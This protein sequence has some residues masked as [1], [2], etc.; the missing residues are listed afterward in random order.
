MA[1]ETALTFPCRDQQLVGIIHHPE[2]EGKTGVLIIVGGPQYRVGSHRQFVLLA[3]HLANAGIT[4]MRFD[5]GGMGDSQGQPRDFLQIDADIRAAIDA[6]MANCPA[7]QQVVLW[8]LCDAA[9]ATLFYGYQDSRV[10]GLVLLNPWVFTQQGAAKTYLK[11]YYLQRLVSKDF[12]R[13]VL[14]LKLDYR[15]SLLSLMG[16]LQQAAGGAA[17]KSTAVAKV[18]ANLPLPARMRQCLSQFNQPVLLILSGRDLTADEFKEVVKADLE[19]QTLL[20]KP[21]L[22]RQD[23]PE[24]DHTFA[25][26]AWREQVAEWTA[27]WVKDVF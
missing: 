3:R 24:A 21:S 11:H 22:S 4:V 19:W 1:L 13:K 14:S 12:W 10:K 2:I 9:S 26:A 7:I 17:K 15:A 27:A 20:A 18:D 23:L 25:A 6:F 8:G 16:L 5:V